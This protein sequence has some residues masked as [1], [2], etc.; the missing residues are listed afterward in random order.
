MRYVINF[1]LNEDIE[2]IL[3]KSLKQLK[4][5]EGKKVL[6]AGA[7]GFL[8]RYFSEIIRKYNIENDTKISLTS[9]DNFI[10]SK[11][12]VMNDE[13]HEFYKIRRRYL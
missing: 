12:K 7:K 9:I 13:D 8:G 10:S 5:L 6:L 4:V 3:K 1:Y 11:F 2:E